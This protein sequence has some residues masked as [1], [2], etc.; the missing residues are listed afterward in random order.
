MKK[1]FKILNIVFITGVSF[2]LFSVSYA[3]TSTDIDDAFWVSE[4][5]SEEEF[6]K[7]LD[8]IKNNLVTKGIIAIAC[9]QF[10]NINGVSVN[11]DPAV[12]TDIQ[13]KINNE[14]SLSVIGRDGKVFKKYRVVNLSQASLP[15]LDEESVL[16]LRKIRRNV[17]RAL[18]FP[19]GFPV[20][21]VIDGSLFALHHRYYKNYKFLP[22]QC[23][24]NAELVSNK[25]YHGKAVIPTADNIFSFAKYLHD[26]AADSVNIH[27]CT[28][29]KIDHAV[30][31]KTEYLLYDTR[32]ELPSTS[33][34]DEEVLPIVPDDI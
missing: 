11:C 19:A 1:V 5:R 18:R 27:A 7:K 20:Y 22:S 2:F 28:G 23:Y 15:P 9:Q 13:E 6:L 14:G 21:S 33:G 8:T 3:Q 31:Y 30:K 32:W 24:P 26:K 34:M 17:P 29:Y 25:G 16:K 10:D 4:A 12:L